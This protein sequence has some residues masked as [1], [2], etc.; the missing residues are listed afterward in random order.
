MKARKIPALCLTAALLVGLCACETAGNPAVETTDMAAS[1][2]PAA[3]KT[4]DDETFTPYEQTAEPKLTSPPAASKKYNYEIDLN[5]VRLDL[6]PAELKNESG[7]FAFPGLEW[8]TEYKEVVSALGESAL[9][10]AG[11][12]DPG[13]WVVLSAGEYEIQLV[14]VFQ[15]RSGTLIGVSM[16]AER[17]EGYR[18]ELSEKTETVISEL[19]ELYGEPEISAYEEQG[20]VDGR[21]ASYTTTTYAWDGARE[22]GF[23]RLMVSS[24]VLGENCIALSV[25]LGNP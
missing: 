22:D 25:I 21:D 10:E 2:L 7:N 1:E 11:E 24:S 9:P 18:E 13:V 15:F 20:R 3:D 4:P 17:G 14:P 5:D 8:G 19:T 16:D 6:S 23:N 12:R